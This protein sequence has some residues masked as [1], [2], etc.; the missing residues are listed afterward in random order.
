MGVVL[1]LIHVCDQINPS[2]ISTSLQGETGKLKGKTNKSKSDFYLL[3]LLQGLH[4]VVD[5][6]L[7][8]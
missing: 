6:I 1:L 8:F 7:L 5:P 4:T 2:S 3:L